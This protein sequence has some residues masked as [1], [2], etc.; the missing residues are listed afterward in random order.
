MYS[1]QKREYFQGE[2]CMGLS[3]MTV[4]SMYDGRWVDVPGL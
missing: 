3:P 2:G 4:D 1:S